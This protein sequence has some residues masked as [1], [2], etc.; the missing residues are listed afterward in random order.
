MGFLIR[1]GQIYFES[2]TD[3]SGLGDKHN[4]C[5]INGFLW[6]T[7]QWRLLCLNYSLLRDRLF[8]S[9][10]IRFSLLSV[11]PLN[12]C[13]E[14]IYADG[15]TKMS[16]EFTD[17][18]QFWWYYG[19]KISWYYNSDNNKLIMFLLYFFSLYQTYYTFYVC[20]CIFLYCNCYIIF[21]LIICIVITNINNV[22]FNYANLNG[23]HNNR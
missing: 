23:N 5:L 13:D 20:E 10:Y 16:C 15:H 7:M 22:K 3:Y 14:L 12:H 18:I 8:E 11:S 2:S 1:S 6:I 17:F 4:N 9:V 21:I 19:S